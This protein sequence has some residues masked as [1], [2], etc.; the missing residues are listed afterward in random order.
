MYMS[1]NDVGQ[2]S[3]MIFINPYSPLPTLLLDIHLY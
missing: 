1:N 2:G 3:A